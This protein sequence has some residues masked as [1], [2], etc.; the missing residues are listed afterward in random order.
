MS[1]ADEAETGRP[2]V[3]PYSSGAGAADQDQDQD[4]AAAK[5]AVNAETQMIPVLDTG[6]AVVPPKIQRAGTDASQA[7]VAKV[8]AIA[9]RSA[10]ALP[11]LGED[12]PREVPTSAK[13]TVERRRRAQ[14]RASG[15]GS[16]SADRGCRPQRPGSCPGNRPGTGAGAAGAG[17]MV[18]DRTRAGARPARAIPGR[19]PTSAKAECGRLPRRH[20]DRR[21]TRAR[22][23]RA[24]GPA[25]DAGTTPNVPLST[26]L[27]TAPAPALAPGTAPG[28]APDAGPG[29]GAGAADR[30]P[31][32][33]P[34]AQGPGSQGLGSQGLGS[35]G[36]VPSDLAPALVRGNLAGWV[37][38]EC[39]R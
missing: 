39:G 34:G 11:A 10:A 35:E 38:P 21:S 8:R 19:A 29:P 37:E 17:G 12:G 9:R 28:T 20:A 25:P 27:S 22:G 24:V 7:D 4:Q 1:G 32:T 31:A 3:G 14:G 6:P 23:S 30:A 15:E 26:A 36:L 18:G 2:R 13:F 5:A 33:V 16:G